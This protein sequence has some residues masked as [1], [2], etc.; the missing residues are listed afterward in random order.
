MHQ[1]V[2][3]VSKLSRADIH[4]VVFLFD[5]EGEGGYLGGHCASLDR[6]VEDATLDHFMRPVRQYWSCQPSSVLAQDD[7]VFQ[8]RISS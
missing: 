7:R 4:Q 2:R 8:L 6:P 1:S 3:R 5:A